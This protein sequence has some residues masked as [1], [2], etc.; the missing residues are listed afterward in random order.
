MG[1]PL[2]KTQ[3]KQQH[4]GRGVYKG[5]DID[6]DDIQRASRPCTTHHAPC[7]VLY[8]EAMCIGG[9]LLLA[10]PIAMA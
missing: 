2:K 1:S 5:F 4:R 3:K 7:G 9:A 6:L 10:N 8:V